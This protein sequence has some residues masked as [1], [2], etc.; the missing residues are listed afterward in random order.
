MVIRIHNQLDK[1][2]IAELSNLASSNMEKWELSGPLNAE[3]FT[4]LT[5]EFKA[6]ATSANAVAKFRIDRPK[7]KV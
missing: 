5:V 7:S 4:E 3:S 1:D 2:Y 6:G